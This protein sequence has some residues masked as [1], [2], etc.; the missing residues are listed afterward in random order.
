MDLPCETGYVPEF[1]TT[2][3]YVAQEKTHRFFFFKQQILLGRASVRSTMPAKE[4][5]EYKREPF[6]T[7]SLNTPNSIKKTLKKHLNM[8]L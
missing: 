3:F 5:K 2:S 7:G 1:G 8:M 4:E 6:I